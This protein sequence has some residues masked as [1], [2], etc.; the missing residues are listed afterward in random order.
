MKICFP[1]VENQSIESRVHGRFGTAKLFL[2]VDSDT[3]QVEH[4]IPCDP[5]DGPFWNLSTAGADAVV[6]GNIGARSLFELERRGMKVFQ[7]QK[8]TVADNLE[9]MA[10][11]GLP[12]LTDAVDLDEVGETGRGRGV[13]F[14]AGA[15]FGA[16][17]GVRCGLGRGSGRGRGTGR[18]A[19]LGFGRGNR[20]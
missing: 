10:K 6:V 18:G 14:G 7:A 9:S 3:R 17:R 4:V 16:G 15:G 1:V 13:G 11:S 19:G 5:A 8:S 20:Y 2:L 12:E